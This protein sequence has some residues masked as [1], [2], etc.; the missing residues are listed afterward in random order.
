VRAGELE[1]LAQQFDEQRAAFDFG[2]DALVVDR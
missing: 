1:M 2:A